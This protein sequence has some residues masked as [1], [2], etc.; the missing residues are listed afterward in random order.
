MSRTTNYGLRSLKKRKRAERSQKLE[1]FSQD[2]Y[3][4]INQILGDQTLREIIAEQLPSDTG[5][6][7]VTIPSGEEFENSWHHVCKKRKKVWNSQTVGIQNIYDHP[8]DTLCQS[9]SVLKFLGLIESGDVSLTKKIQ[10]RMVAMWHGLLDNEKIKEQIIHS[11][12]EYT[13]KKSRGVNRRDYVMKNVAPR[14]PKIITKIR[15]VLK[16]WENFGWE[17]FMLSS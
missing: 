10:T 4:Y 1:K 6:K 9:Y 17:Y 15:Q 3:W 14:G 12:M 16:D 2:H 7:L 5:W 13:V 11:V 8:N